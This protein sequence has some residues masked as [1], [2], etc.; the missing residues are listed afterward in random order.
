MIESLNSKENNDIEKIKVTS[1]KIVVCGKVDKPYFQIEYHLLENGECH[2]GYGSYDLKFVFS[3]LSE[4]F[5][6]VE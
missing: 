3:W 5:D 6:I 1:A 2:I 4:C